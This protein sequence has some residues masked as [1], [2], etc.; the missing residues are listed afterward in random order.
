MLDSG[1]CDK[2]WERELEEAGRQLGRSSKLGAE[3]W[4]LRRAESKDMKLT[5]WEGRHETGELGGKT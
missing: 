4:E 2:S 1:S 5:S 3:S